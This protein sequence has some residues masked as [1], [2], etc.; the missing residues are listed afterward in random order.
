MADSVDIA[1]G[2][3]IPNANEVTTVFTSPTSQNGTIVT[4]FSASNSSGANASYKAYIFNA[5]GVLLDPIIPLKVV[6][7]NRFD[8]GASIINQK[9]PTGGTLRIENNIGDSII[10][11]IT[12]S[13]V[14]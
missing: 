2:I 10:F 13:S 8:L 5:N 4:A 7:R 6:V 9:I 1:S 12:G 14:D 3:K 11:F